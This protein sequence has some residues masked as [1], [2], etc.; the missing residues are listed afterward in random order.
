MDTGQTK[1][2]STFLSISNN[3]HKLKSENVGYSYTQV[4]LHVC[5]GGQTQV[6]LIALIMG[7]LLLHT[8]SLVGSKGS[9]FLEVFTSADTCTQSLLMGCSCSLP[10]LACVLKGHS[11]PFLSTCTAVFESIHFDRVPGSLNSALLNTHY[12]P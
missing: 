9:I 1:R 12:A 7:L 8:R 5:W 11:P 10:S 6:L 3:K 2:T 4:C